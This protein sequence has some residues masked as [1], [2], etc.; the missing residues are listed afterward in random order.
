M[1]AAD[2]L[3]G[4]QLCQPHRRSHYCALAFSWTG[5]DRSRFGCMLLAE[6][7]GHGVASSTGRVAGISTRGCHGVGTTD[8]EPEGAVLASR[9]FGSYRDQAEGGPG[10]SSWGPLGPEAG[11][12]AWWD[13]AGGDGQSASTGAYPKMAKLTTQ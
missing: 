11:S 9:R 1:L 2:I 4:R 13:G 5:V 3:A 12:A 10:C 8:V 7:S 6:G